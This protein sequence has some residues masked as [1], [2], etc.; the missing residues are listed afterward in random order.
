MLKKIDKDKILA[1]EMYC[2]RRILRLRW[3][4]KV[5]NTEVR[6]RLG[7]GEDLFQAVMRR[8]LNLFGHICRMSSD[9]KIKSVMLG[10]MDGTGK[11]GRPNR[12]WLDDVRDWC[13]EE[14]H[15]LQSVAQDRAEWKRKVNLALGTYG[16]SAHG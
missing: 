13:H 5:T 16:L 1:F 8:K 14:V 2:Y 10:I 3:T 15:K 12:E 6:V 7:I 11:K 4:Q 9:R